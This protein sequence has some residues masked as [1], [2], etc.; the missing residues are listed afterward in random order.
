[1][2]QTMIRIGNFFFK[3]RNKAFPIIVVALFALALP[4]QTVLGSTHLADV[5]DL[6]AIALALS[7]LA[8]RGVVIGYAYIKRGGLNKKVY[9]ENLVT[10][11]MF[12]VC[13]N[14]LY[15]GNVLIY[16][17][18]FLLH[19]D[20][21]VTISGIVVFLF[22]YQCIV[23]AEEA[24]L[25]DKFGEGYQHYC[26]DVPRWT[27]ALSKFK[28]STEGMKFNFTRAIMKDYS[29]IA[30]TLVM[31]ALTQLY[32]ILAAPA[33]APGGVSVMG[34]GAFMVAIILCALLIRVWKKNTSIQKA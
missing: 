6:V 21:L 10:E 12:G 26:A 27:L 30:T 16:V 22:I 3:T 19:G 18:V 29:T 4:A 32:K 8:V 17:G 1:M 5:K 20:L 13:R 25:A 14:P 33:D 34:L 11:G 23:L 28:T 2:K 15:V 31:L 7:G 24:Y 9:A